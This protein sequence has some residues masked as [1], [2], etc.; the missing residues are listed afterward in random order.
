MFIYVVVHPTQLF[1]IYILYCY[2]V[3]QPGTLLSGCLKVQSIKYTVISM[4]AF[5]G[6]I[7][8]Q[9]AGFCM[10][11]NAVHLQEYLPAM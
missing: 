10:C 1:T 3:Y 6:G 8:Q 4:T 9:A 11:R 5:F 7:Q 2:L